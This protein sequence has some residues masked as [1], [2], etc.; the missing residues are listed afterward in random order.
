MWGHRL[1]NVRK[2]QKGGVMKNTRKGQFAQRIAVI[3]LAVIMGLS[4]SA[5]NI[6]FDDDD[7]GGGGSTQ[8]L[9]GVWQ[10]SS[11]IQ[12]TVSG[13]TGVL[14]AF[15]NNLSDYAKS[16]ITKG[17]IK[18]GSTFWQ[19]LTSTGNLTW[20]G[21]ELYVRY[22]ASTNVATGTT[23]SDTCIFTLSADGQTLTVYDNTDNK[24]IT[25]TWTRSAGSSG[26]A[27]TGVTLNPTILSLTVGGTTN[28]T[29]TVSPSTATNKSLIWVSGN[30]SVATVNNNGTVTAVSAGTATITVITVDGGKAATC[31]VTVGGGGVPGGNVFTSIAAMATWLSA[32]PDNTPATPYTV[33]L[34]VSSLGGNAQA[35]GSAGTALRNNSTKYV[36]LDL[37]GS[38]LTTIPD[39]SFSTSST[40]YS[41]TTLVG[42][43]LPNSVTSIGSNAFRNTSLTE[44]IIPDS[45]ISIEANAFNGCRSL[46]A[47]TLGNSVNSIKNYVFQNCTALASVTIPNSVTS[48]GNYAFNGCAALA[49]VTIPN[50]VT[51]IGTNAF[52]GCTSLADITFTPTSRVASIGT[53]AFQGCTALINVTIPNSV[54]SIGQQAFYQCTGLTS[55]IIGSGVTDIGASAFAGCTSLTNVRFERAGTSMT[56]SSFYNIGSGTT[57]LQQVYQNGG[58]G[59]YIRNGS[60][61]TKQ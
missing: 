9:D 39:D 36:I 15:G 60:N 46:A 56:S 37:S 55:I 34:N 61:W 31:L 53:S 3:A 1:F 7:G 19:N 18:I 57:G 52:Q 25:S 58:A 23:W 12:V 45:V 2:T 4:M 10:T 26:G 11:G 59:T 28:L 14:S 47:V 50:S 16:A 6:D 13:N 32:Q 51:S 5:C 24:N 38:T 8:S 30:D 48:I 22:N 35:N 20:S 41:C 29:A 17:Y 44:I 33:K 21:Q 43:I 40:T 54:T 27:V 42:V 49:N